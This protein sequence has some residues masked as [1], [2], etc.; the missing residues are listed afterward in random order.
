MP[1]VPASILRDVRR[2]LRTVF[3]RPSRVRRLIALGPRGWA[4][5]ARYLVRVLPE[6]AVDPSKTG[7]GLEKRLMYN[8]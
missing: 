7:S 4:A 1:R 6:A 5:T 2:T 3:S 8:H